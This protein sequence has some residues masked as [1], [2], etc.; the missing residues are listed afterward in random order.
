[1]PL[2]QSLLEAAQFICVLRSRQGQLITA[3]EENAYFNG[4]IRL[5][6][7]RGSTRH[8]PSRFF[9]PDYSANSQIIRP[10]VAPGVQLAESAP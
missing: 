2:P 9:H 7:S 10:R 4:W 5:A 1:M 6:F 3:P 8:F